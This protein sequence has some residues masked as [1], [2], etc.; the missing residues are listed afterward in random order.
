MLDTLKQVKVTFCAAVGGR[1]QTD[2]LSCQ[3]PYPFVGVKNA[4]ETIQGLGK[5]GKKPGWAKVTTY[6]LKLYI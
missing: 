6:W 3:G 5:N 1:G 2:S 4:R